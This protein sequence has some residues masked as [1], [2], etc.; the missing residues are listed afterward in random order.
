MKCVTN[1]AGTQKAGIQYAGPIYGAALVMVA[2]VMAS[3]KS[4]VPTRLKSPTSGRAKRDRATTAGMAVSASTAGSRICELLRDAWK[5]GAR[6]QKHQTE[7]PECMQQ[8]Y[9]KHNVSG[10]QRG[11][12]RHQIKFSCHAEYDGAE[13]QI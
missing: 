12:P 8:K 11:E 2:S 5:Y 9:G 6:R 4:S 7:M 3:A 10:F 1:S 13:Q